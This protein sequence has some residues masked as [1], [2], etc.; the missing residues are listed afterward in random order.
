MSASGRI[1]LPSLGQFDKGNR[2]DR[3]RRA[4][5]QIV[6]VRAQ[7]VLSLFAK[8][9]NFNTFKPAVLHDRALKALLDQ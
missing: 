2:A 1:P 7:V 4:E 9:E 5:L 8:F 3:C 6:D